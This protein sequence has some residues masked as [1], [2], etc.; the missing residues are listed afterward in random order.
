VVRSLAFLALLALGT[1]TVCL[2]FLYDEALVVQLVPS[3]GQVPL[4]SRI[5][6]LSILV[7]ISRIWYLGKE[8]VVLRCVVDRS[9]V[10][11]F[12]KVSVSYF[13]IGELQLC[14]GFAHMGA[15]LALGFLAHHL[16]VLSPFDHIFVLGGFWE[17]P[18]GVA[19]HIIPLLIKLVQV[20]YQFSLLRVVL[21][22]GLAFENLGIGLIT[23]THLVE[24]LIGVGVARVDVR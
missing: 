11:M 14:V 17:D 13:L 5:T 22:A 21:G 8:L 12:L 15:L 19:D 20:P 1:H 2:H 16:V 10:H 3:A 24:Q 18:Q 4:I 7:S 23:E 6:M 9:E